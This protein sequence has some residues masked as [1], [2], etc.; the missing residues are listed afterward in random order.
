MLTQ[1]G[2]CS[3]S[4]EAIHNQPPAQGFSAS[5]NSIWLDL[6]FRKNLIHVSTQGRG[7]PPRTPWFISYRRLTKQLMVW[8]VGIADVS[9][10]FD[11][12]DHWILLRELASFHIDTVFINWISAFL[13]GDRKLQGLVTL[14]LI[15]GHPGEVSHKGR[16][17]VWFCL[18]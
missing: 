11:L 13:T 14:C 4:A 8:I 15:G 7:T 9:K 12:I 10:G 18:L 16:N 1:G 3:W 2:I 6:K 5:R 17:W